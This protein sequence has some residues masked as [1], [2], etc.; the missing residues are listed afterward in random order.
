[1]GVSQGLGC[2]F[3]FS[4]LTWIA[5][6]RFDALHLLKALSLFDGRLS[7]KARRLRHRQFRRVVRELRTRGLDG[8]LG[9]S[10]FQLCSQI[11]VR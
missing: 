1:M 3:S 6:S 4:P 2:R 8:S 11:I 7:R 9:L 10:L 5:A